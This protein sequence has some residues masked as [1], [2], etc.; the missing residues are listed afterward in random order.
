MPRAVSPTTPVPAAESQRSP[1]RA[2]TLSELPKLTALTLASAIGGGGGTGGGGSTVFGLLLAIGLLAG[3]SG[4]DRAAGPGDAPAPVRSQ[5]LTCVVR[6]DAATIDCA[7]P[8]ADAP[9]PSVLGGQGR[10]VGL[11]STNVS[12]DGGA[13][14]LSADV[15]V[16]NLS[17]QPMGTTDGTTINGGIDVFF[18][19]LP[20]GAVT[21]DN[22]TGTGTFTAAGQP[23]F[24]YDT[25]LARG[26]LSMPLTW[27]FGMHGESSFT[28]SVLI[29]TNIPVS[30][31]IM[32]WV[33]IP[34]LSP[35]D[36]TAITGYG[37]DMVAVSGG[38][39]E[40]VVRNGGAWIPRFDT[41]DPGSISG[42][43]QIAAV[44]PNEIYRYS[45]NTFEL[46]QFDGGSWRN[47]SALP[48]APFGFETMQVMGPGDLY[49]FH[50]DVDRFHNGAWTSVPHPSFGSG[51]PKA[52]TKV[53]SVIYMTTDDGEVWTFDG[54]TW[55]GIGNSGLNHPDAIAATG[56]GD[57]WVY[58]GFGT[59]GLFLRHWDGASWS[60]VAPPGTPGSLQ[61]GRDMAAGGPG[62]IYIVGYNGSS[63]GFVWFFDGSSWTTPISGGG[64]F[65]S[66]WSRSP[67]SVYVAGNG[68]RVKHW[69]G[70]IWEDLLAPVQAG[71]SVYVASQNNIWA[72]RGAKTL[73]RWNGH[74]WSTTLPP[75]TTENLRMVWGTSGSD[76][77]IVNSGYSVYHFNGASW[78]ISEP[79]YTY[80]T[81]QSAVGGSGPNDVWFV[82]SGSTAHWNGS[83]FTEFPVPTGEFYLD[84]IAFSPTD[85]FAVG[86]NGSIIHWDGTSW[87]T[88]SSGTAVMLR[89][90]WGRSSTDVWAFG[91]DGSA[92]HWNG[93]TWSDGG[94]AA[95]S[96]INDSWGTPSGL[97]YAVGSSVAKY[98]D[99]SSWS[100]LKFGA[101]PYINLNA[102]AGDANGAIIVGERFLRGVK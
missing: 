66:V 79:L 73:M 46:R 6:R 29:S 85:A 80:N 16:E 39:G 42:S 8:L 5:V 9:T 82:G 13:D 95:G 96:A 94:L 68:G 7:G 65:Y 64:S 1:W 2:P 25:L 78:T 14:V 3:C 97:V 67:S 40:M 84:V 58:T 22:P 74:T 27:E 91:I 15:T 10:L 83:A 49:V 76:V 4:A 51:L 47:L 63:Q 62:Q 101:S 34:E 90:I 26:D 32:A 23:Y 17:N 55:T 57:I 37:S 43:D 38:V 59:G 21:V 31:G 77:W 72:I 81:Y 50:T 56:I 36:W 89:A 45:T 41:D 98:W 19:V 48:G 102:I 92:R 53:G 35:G 11:R 20:S 30:D 86:S 28:F 54:T 93:A 70:S 44:S 52:S 99:G 60:T 71:Q 24:H 75:D 61:Y 18:T 12:Y 100:D 69:N 88:M 33:A 87:S